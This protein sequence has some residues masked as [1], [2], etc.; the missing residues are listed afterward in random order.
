MSAIFGYCHTDG[1]P[2][3]AD[4]LGSMRSVMNHWNA[5]S[6]RLWTGEHVAMGHLLLQNSPQSA[7][8][9]Q[10]LYADSL[11]LAITADATLFNRPELSKELGISLKN[12]LTDSALI[13]KSFQKWGKEC[14]RHL[15]GNFA[16]AI[17]N[18]DKRELFCARDHHGIKPLFY[19]HEG[20]TFGFSSEIKGLMALPWI[21]KG[22]D[23]T[24]IA[25]FLCRIWL[26]RSSTLYSHV[27]RLEPAQVLILNPQGLQI[28]TYWHP[29]P[30]EEL[31]LPSDEAYIETFKHQ[32]HQAIERRTNSTHTISSEL[33]GGL[34]SSAITLIGRKFSKDLKPYSYVLP[35]GAHYGKL[36]DE[37]KEIE[38]IW[39]TGGIENG[40]MLT[41]E[42]HG[43]L[44]A[45][46]W[47]HRIHDEP[48]KEMN[49]MF[50][51]QL[52]AQIAASGSR[53]LL[54]GFGG[55]DIV[56]HHGNGYLEELARTGKWKAALEEIK[57]HAK[58]KDQSVALKTMSLLLRGLTG[59]N[60]E[61]H[62][63]L[64]KKKFF[65]KERPVRE[66][67]RLR[68]LRQD[69]FDR[70]DMEQRFDA[71]QKRYFRTGQF[72]L[73]QIRRLQQPHVMH[74]L[75]LCDI[76]TRSFKI[77][78]QYPLLDMELIELY[79]SLPMS[80]KVKNG[81]GRYIFRKAI[82]GLM[83]D[84]L[85]WRH[86]KKGSSNP[87]IV[88]R[89]Q[90]DGN[91]VVEA[92]NTLPEGHPVLNYADFKRTASMEKFVLNGKERIWNQQTTH[93]MNLLLAK[94]MASNS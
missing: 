64:V 91:K 92:L 9:Q 67:L 80:M 90:I 49:C 60:P 93:I 12:E 52:Y 29:E 22:F 58:H 76:A 46:E 57:A 19:S 16:F 83:P 15:N 34:D 44:S 59:F 47:N 35:K 70:H 86:S 73:D 38:Q 4:V 42:G 84:D 68:P 39:Q 3:E 78:Y 87:H 36:Q 63:R 51:E 77:E 21:K 85:L 25:D 75:E 55:D 10:A 62:D 82:E 32:L 26:D 18:R 94:K 40:V 54:S 89:G 7:F 33:S 20:G 27:K 30:K 72:A 61:K 1:K 13:L 31:R 5:D 8:E 43:L 69:L 28:D 48:P 2:A 88:I 81:K 66:K 79:L 74:R 23:E 53:T 14:P 65:S 24:W 41:D 50:R 11:G 56:S 17:W 6:T 37:R 45:I 71:Y